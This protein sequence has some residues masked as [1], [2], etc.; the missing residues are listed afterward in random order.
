MTG[1]GRP[2]V[3]LDWSVGHHETTAAQL[4]PAARVVVERACLQPGERVLDLGC[5]TGN[6]AVLAARAGSMVTGVDPAAR[7]VEVARARAASD[8]VAIDFRPGEAASIPMAEASVDIILSVFA[9]IFATDPGAAATEMS[10]V[11]S[12]VG[13][14]VMSAWLPTGAI[15]EMNSVAAET[16]M[17]AVGIPAPPK[18]FPW[19]DHDALVGLFGPHGFDADLEEHSLVFTAESVEDYLQEEARN[20][21]MAVS[22]VAVLEQLGQAEALRD[23]L[24]RILTEGNEDPRA[25]NATSRYVVA[26]LKRHNT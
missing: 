14:I 15:F 21:P 23:R 3:G 20:H 26:T 18:R 6:G 16:V 22:G 7:L 9:V 13:R 8:G 1:S 24:R 4:A 10:R 11:L 25:F 17:R 5:G 12:P 19:H 2:P